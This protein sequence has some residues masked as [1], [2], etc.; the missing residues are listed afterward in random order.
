[1]WMTS[2]HASEQHTN[3]MRSIRT[4]LIGTTL[5]SAMA[6]SHNVL[7]QAF[8]EGSHT[9]SVGHGAVTFLGNLNRTFETYVDLEY[10]SLGPLYL[11]YEYGVTNRIGL[12]IN[13]AYATNEW[14]YRYETTDDQGNTTTYG[15]STER[16]TYSLLA[17]LNYHF[18][19]SERFDPY[20]GFGVGYRDAN[21]QL[22]SSGPDGG[23][24]VE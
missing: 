11:K 12:G 1:M 23:S 17:R 5:V 19:N 20:F 18:G 10:K 6:G 24:G 13:L 16:D 4:I 14:S 15:E 8:Q 22:N 3:I 7:A 9:L 2:S 21:W